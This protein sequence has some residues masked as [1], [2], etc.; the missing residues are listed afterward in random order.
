MRQS[1]RSRG[2]VSRVGLLVTVAV[3]QGRAAGAGSQSARNHPAS[4]AWPRAPTALRDLPG[5]RAPK[6]IVINL[7]GPVTANSRQALDALQ[8]VAPGV[9]IVAVANADEM[10]AQAA[11][12][13]AIVGGDDTVCDERVLAAAKKLRWVA[14]Y[15]RRRR[16]LPRQ[17]GASRS[18]ASS[19]RTCAP[20][21]GPVMA[22]HTIALMFALSRSLQVSVARQA[23]GEGWSGNFAGSEPQALTGKTL[24]VAGPRRHRH[25]KSRGARMR[26]A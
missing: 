5:W 8:A 13:D 19:S 12:A 25:S 6:R 16:S 4:S 7:N 2:L 1:M 3:G 18:P 24:L 20:S 11:D 9:E 22:E 23:N 14:V 26:S 15:L 17:E 21:P 10:I